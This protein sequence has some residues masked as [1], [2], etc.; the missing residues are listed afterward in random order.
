MVLQTINSSPS[1]VP[2]LLD[3]LYVKCSQCAVNTICARPE[4]AWRY[5]Y[6]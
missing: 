6:C 5:V 2:S 3:P 4:I 1:M